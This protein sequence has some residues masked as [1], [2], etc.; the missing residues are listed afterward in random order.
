MKVESSL[1][2]K[3]SI[4]LEAIHGGVGKALV[5]GLTVAHACHLVADYVIPLTSKPL[6]M[7]FTVLSRV[8]SIG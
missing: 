1:S 4:R 3:E 7:T 8:G 6:V 5:S 2:I